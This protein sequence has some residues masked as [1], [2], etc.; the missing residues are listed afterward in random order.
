M[1]RFTTALGLALL[2]L[3]TLSAVA[4]G[5]TV[6]ETALDEPE[7]GALASAGGLA[8]IVTVVTNLVRGL[9]DPVSFDRLG[10]LIATVV[11]VVLSLAYTFATSPITSAS[12]L[13]AVLVGVVGGALSNPINNAVSRLGR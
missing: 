11:A 5:Q 13:Q 6:A 7:I 1:N 3:L 8:V 2:A 12:L 9:I 10:P 4:L